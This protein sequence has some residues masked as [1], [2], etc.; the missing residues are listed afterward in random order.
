MGKFADNGG[1][2]YVAQGA[3]DAAKP[4]WGAM[5]SKGANRR[6]LRQQKKLMGLEMKGNKEMADYEQEL[7]MDMWEKT[8]YA[9]QM[10]QLDKAGLNPSLMYGGGGQGGTTSGAGSAGSV[11]GGNAAY[12][13]P[14]MALEGIQASQVAL[15]KAQKENIEAD[16]ANKKADTTKTS[17][18]D[19]D[20]VT[21]SINAMKQATKNAE[22]QH[23]IG[24]YQ[25]KLAE[26]ESNVSGATAEERIA[27][28]KAAT[29]K[30]QGE[31]K[32]ATTKG[33][34]DETVQNEIIKNAQLANQELNVR[35]ENTKATT[36]QTKQNTENLKQDE[37]QKTLENQLR[38]NGV[39]PNDSPAMRIVSRVI[40]NAGTSLEKM[41]RKM[42]AIVK[43]LKG[44]NGS[45]TKERF[46]E[47]WNE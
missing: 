35:I 34:V 33:T 4:M 6:Q 46:E 43:W 47:I 27:Q 12:E 13:N 20:A 41:Q 10:E 16:T 3:S 42:S 25:K 21:T 44:E 26:I 40:N 37:I 11:G 9:A 24:E 30:L 17:T 7:A 22:L 19:T 36:E 38:E 18:V 14:G 32:S 8:N 23:A 29:D 31:A 5:F 39:Q 1:W 15:M 45:Q 28:A 2:G